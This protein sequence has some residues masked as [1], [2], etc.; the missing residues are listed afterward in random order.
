MGE[1]LSHD[2]QDA[3]AAYLHLARSLHRLSAPQEEVAK[4]AW[5]AIEHDL[6]RPILNA[7]S[8]YHA[9]RF[10]RGEGPL[11]EEAR[12]RV[13]EIIDLSKARFPEDVVAAQHRLELRLAHDLGQ[14][15]EDWELLMK[16]GQIHAVPVEEFLQQREVQG[17]FNLAAEQAYRMGGLPSSRYACSLGPTPRLP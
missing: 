13:S 11:S 9:A 14:D 5:T 10:Q 7:Q 3:A 12:R 1:Y 8:L 2:P 15:A 17:G 4:A 6:Q 16:A